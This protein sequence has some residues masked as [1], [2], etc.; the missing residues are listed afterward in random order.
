MNNMK[1]IIYENRKSL[2]LT[3]KELGQLINVSDKQISKWETGV[4]YP[5]ITLI[6]KLAEVLN[7]SVNELL[8][9]NEITRDKII[10]HNIL[11]Q[12][13]M[14][15]FI[16]LISLVIS[17]VVFILG[18]LIVQVANLTGNVILVLSF[19]LLLFSIIY[20]V[21]T[22]IKEKDL[23][24]NEHKEHVLKTIYY[25]KNLIFIN[26]ILLFLT[27]FLLSTSLF[28]FNIIII[29][30]YF[31]ISNLFSFLYIIASLILLELIYYIKV[32]SNVNYRYPK[33]LKI[34][35]IL[36]YVI[37]GLI[38]ILTTVINLFFNTVTTNNVIY[39][40]FLTVIYFIKIFIPIVILSNLVIYYFIKE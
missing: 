38:L 24:N 36:L 17:M 35:R 12:F 21:A 15:R 31:T 40:I 23:I 13:K 16:S 1:T 22:N 4:S 30:R 20:L 39:N 6:S 34:L 10:N 9:S 8:E 33:A 11:N 18:V 5:D 32:S 26:I 37:M 28:N 14:S 19:A 2:G 7:I 25:Y 3:Q 29:F 27:A